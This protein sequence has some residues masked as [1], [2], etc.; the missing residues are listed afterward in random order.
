ME[1]ETP[2]VDYGPLAGL[3]GTWSGEKGMDIAPEPNATE[4]NP[5]YETIVF[6]A[7]G[8]LMNGEEQKVSMLRYLQ[9]V[10]RKS[11]DEVFHDQTGYWMWDAE[12]KMVMHSLVIPRGLSLL[13]GGNH[14]T[15]GTSIRIDVKSSL[16]DPDFGIAQSPFLNAKAKTSAFKMTVEIDG[17]TLSY[18]EVTDLDIYG[19]KF[20]HIDSN[21][22]VRVK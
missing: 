10:K 4:E 8:D 20:D 22:L 7:C 17:D 9:I 18:N 6:E 13:A 21:E 16:D 5:Y 15:N 3:I 1:Q 12:A 14:T 2:E 11:N 19:R